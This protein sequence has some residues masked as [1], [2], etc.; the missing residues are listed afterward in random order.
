MHL[1]FNHLGFIVKDLD[2]NAKFYENTLNMKRVTDIIYDPIQKVNLMFLEDQN[3]KGLIYELIQPVYKDSP[4]SQWLDKGNTLQHICYEVEDI[5]EGIEYFVNKG[6]YLFVEPVPA[7]A[8]N[9]RLIAF[10][11]TKEKLII[12]LLDSSGYSK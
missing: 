8:F 2:E 1:K 11:L 10:L 9:N 3:I 4:S 7:I 6:G 5:K 12:E